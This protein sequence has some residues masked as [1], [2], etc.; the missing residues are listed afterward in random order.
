MSEILVCLFIVGI[1]AVAFGAKMIYCGHRQQPE[2]DRRHH[3]RR[4]SW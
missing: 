3:E 4:G 1:I 2:F